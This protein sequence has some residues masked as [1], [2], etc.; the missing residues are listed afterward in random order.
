MGKRFPHRSRVRAAPSWI[1]ATD[2]GT[3]RPA[4]VSG[5]AERRRSSVQPGRW[6]TKGD[7]GERPG[8]LAR[9]MVGTPRGQATAGV[10][11]VEAGAPPDAAGH[12][13]RAPAAAAA[14]A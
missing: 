8:A 11:A 4:A 13:V 3:K 6:A 14:G 10:R 5:R 12:G 2:G 9:E 1:N 7:A